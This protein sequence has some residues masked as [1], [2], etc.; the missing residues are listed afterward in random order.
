MDNRY[1][2]FKILEYGRTIYHV[3][4]C[5]N[6]LASVQIPNQMLSL[7]TTK[8]IDIAELNI[9]CCE[10]PEYHWTLNDKYYKES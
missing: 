6:C 8:C 3:M 1:R 4:H 7:G 10:K 2:I 9:P 5:H